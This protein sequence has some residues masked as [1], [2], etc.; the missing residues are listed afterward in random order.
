MPTVKRTDEFSSWL[1][2]L[3]DFRAKA[4]ILQRIDRLAQGNPGDVAPVG[5]GLKRDEDTLRPLGTGFT[6]FNMVKRSLFFFAA[7]TRALR[8]RT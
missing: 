4:K 1:K 7:E 3:R 5:S 8:V 6:S 2:K